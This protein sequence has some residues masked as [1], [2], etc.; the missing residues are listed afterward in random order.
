M[1][2][3][4]LVGKLIEGIKIAEDK[5][6]LLFLTDAGEVIARADADCCSST[7]IE[8]VEIPFTEFPC[9][10]LRVEDIDMPDL[11]SMPGCD[12]MAYY[13]FKIATDK[14]DI[15]IDY[16]NDSNGYYGGNIE[17]P[18]G[19][20]YGGVYGQNVSKCVWVDINE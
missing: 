14:G 7:W 4:I 16:R 20:F 8:S 10:V 19:D 18:D 15:I 2:E 11:G 13:G 17:W 3:N 9:R 6:A 12:V 1:K 5:M